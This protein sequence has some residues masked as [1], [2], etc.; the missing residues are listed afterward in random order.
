MKLQNNFL[1]IVIAAIGVYAAFL[2]ISDYNSISEKISFFQLEYLLPILTLVSVSWIPLILRWNIL[3]KQNGISVPIKKS[4]MIWLSGSALG[5]TPGQVGELLKS[6]ILKNLFNIPRSKTAPIIFIEKFYDLIGAIIASTLGI[7][8]LGMDYNLI[9]VSIFILGILFF[10]I[11]YRKAFEYLLTKITKTKFFSKYSDNLSDSHTTIRNSTNPKLASISISL[12]LLYWLIIS[13]AAYLTLL[14]FDINTIG[15]LET[16]AIYTASVLIGVVT[17]I[18][19]GVGITEGSLTG[20]FVLQGVDISVAL[21]ISV[22]IR[23]LTLWYSV[24]IGF[25][26]LKILG[27]F[28]IKHNS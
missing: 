15:I 6:Q 19:G 9:L 27:G 25:I 17:F 23:I 3:L 7:I 21:V 13:V 14:A 20:L 12:S 8:V 5:I 4:I 11:Y 18:P 28:T 2:F 10:F 24:S 16:I 1:L 22:V 26:C